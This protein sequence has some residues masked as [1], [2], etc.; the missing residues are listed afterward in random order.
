MSFPDS[1]SSLSSLT[2][3][4][5]LSAALVCASAAALISLRGEGSQRGEAAHGA[6]L[7][8]LLVHA[9]ADL[10]GD[11]YVERVFVDV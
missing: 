9:I 6:S 5:E 4:R 1:P 2:R 11:A 10:G 3:S 8:N 7:L